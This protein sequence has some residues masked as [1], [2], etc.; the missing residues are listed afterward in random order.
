MLGKLGVTGFYIQPPAFMATHTKYS[1][2]ILPARHAQQGFV[3]VA[4]LFA[5]A[6]IALG[7]AY[8]AGRVDS[9]RNSAVQTAR[10]A[11]A[12]REAFSLRETIMH[13]AATHLRLEG[14]LSV[15]DAL[16]EDL[17]SSP[18]S[19]STQSASVGAP[20]NAKARIGESLALDGRRYKISDTLTLQVQDERGLIA[21][22]IAETRL[23]ARLFTDMGIPAEQHARLIDG[24]ADYIDIDDLKRLN[25][26]EKN[27]YLALGRMPP[28]ND[29]LRSREEISNIAGWAPIFASLD[30]AEPTNPG[31]RERFLALFSIARHFGLNINSAPAKVLTAYPGIENAR[32][33]ALIDA[34]RIKPFGNVSELLPFAFGRLDDELTGFVDAGTWRVTIAKAEL[35]FLLECTL[36]ISPGDRNKPVQTQACRRRSPDAMSEGGESATNEF[37]VAWRAFNNDLGRND[38]VSNSA[39]SQLSRLGRS[40]SNNPISPPENNFANRSSS[41]FNPVSKANAPANSARETPAPRWLVEATGRAGVI[42]EI[43]NQQ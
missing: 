32:V 43:R 16:P 20:I 10:W 36:I 28:A 39:Q 34:R 19:R 38:D 3:L 22:N 30:Q 26:A 37:A 27:E 5:V 13:A 4:T 40:V 33:M 25:G 42:G 6:L 7:A 15:I 14:G 8:F 24:L 41:I 11:E 12:E 23:L 31:I 35:P 18:I 17:S 9:L 1:R 29:F 2:L 21:I